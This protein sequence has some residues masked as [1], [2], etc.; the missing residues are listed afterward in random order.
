M[1]GRHGLLWVAGAVGATVGIAHA[2]PAFISRSD[3]L[4]RAFGVRER[5]DDSTTIALTFDD[6]PHPQGTPAV[7]E[8][9]AREGAVATFVL[10]GEQVRRHPDLVREI[11]AAGHAVGVHC[12]RHRNL[13]AMTA[14]QTLADMGAAEDAIGSALGAAP[15]LYRPPYGI[16]NGAALVIIRRRRWSSVLWSR[17]PK[18]FDDDASV[19]AIVA[20]TTGDLRGGEIVL[21][22]DSDAY[23]SEGCWRQTAAALPRILDAATSAGMR[24]TRLEP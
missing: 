1:S 5:L 14:R 19:D 6:G 10:V 11:E 23:A 8:A 9:L 18:D 15:A 2:G 7:L 21:L 13:L 24:V 22:H 4:R 17:D 16:F 20:V 3:L 12:D